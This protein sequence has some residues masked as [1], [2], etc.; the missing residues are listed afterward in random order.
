MVFAK[1][2]DAITPFEG[3]VPGTLFDGDFDIFWQ[4]WLVVVKTA[5]VA[6]SSAGILA[7]ESRLSVA[8]PAAAV[9]AVKRSLPS[10]TEIRWVTF[11]KIRLFSLFCHFFL[12]ERRLLFMLL[13]G[14]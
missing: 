5:A 7:A 2:G 11:G 3:T 14:S 8:K 4:H 9:P 12:N 13:P 10:S 6:T 1:K